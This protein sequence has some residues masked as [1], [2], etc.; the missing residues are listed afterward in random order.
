MLNLKNITAILLTTLF[1][2]TSCGEK[3]KPGVES[4][5]SPQPKVFVP[6]FNADSAFAFVSAQTDFGPRMPGTPAHQQCG[7]WLENTLK[8]FS[9]QVIVQP[10]QTRLWNGNVMSGKNIIG[11]FNPDAEKRIL[12][13]A[14]WDT[15]P[16]ADHDPDPLKHN[17][18]IDGAN[19]GASGV[20]TLM[21]VA[22]Q[23]SLYDVKTGVD[24][25][26]FD[27]EDW[28]EPQNTQTSQRDTWALGSQYWANTPHFPGYHA[29]FGILLD[30]VGAPN[31]TFFMEGTSM[32][33]APNIMRK[34]WQTARQIGYGSYFV[35]QEGNPITDDH[36]YINKIAGIPV[37]DIIHLDN[38]TP[39]G[40]FKYWH[41]T[42]DKID[43]ID[44]NTLKAVG[45]TLLQVIYTF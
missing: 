24:I 37:I 16:Y 19:D 10:V 27:L 33:Y 28:G 25:I 31:A 35:M 17:T 22:R 13:C 12:L 14:H 44:P 15:R 26:F 39:H 43:Y 21:E 29:N 40:F 45:Q 42:N 4:D 32:K 3:R 36:Y 11:I 41:T 30:M 23:L 20:G 8:K 9:H 34:V 6:S 38:E 5:I 18:P 7:T 2:A 1:L